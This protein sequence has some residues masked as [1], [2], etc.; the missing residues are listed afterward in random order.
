MI[1]LALPLGPNSEPR[2]INDK[3][4]VVGWMGQSSTIDSHAYIWQNGIVT[5]LGVAPGTFASVASAINNTGQVLVVGNLQ[6]DKSSPVLT[7]SF[8]WE[9]GQWTDIGLLPAFDRCAG[10][11]LND[12]GQAVGICTKSAQ[13]NAADPFVW[14]DGVMTDLNDLPGFDPDALASRAFAINQSGQIIATGGIGSAPV[15][16]A[17]LLLTPINQPLGDLNHDCVVGLTDFLIVIESWGPCPDP[18]ASCFGDADG[19]CQVGILD[20]LAVIGNWTF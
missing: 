8:L 5:D 2:N 13:P 10:L 15:E 1:P 19:D 4:Q 7:R 11:D 14:Q 16:P 20:F 3:G 12:A 9:K 17:G 18:C 6:K